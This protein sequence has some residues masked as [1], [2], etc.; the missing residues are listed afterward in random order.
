MFMTLLFMMPVM[1]GPAST[2][3]YNAPQW[4][5]PIPLAWEQHWRTEAKPIEDPSGNYV[6][7]REAHEK[8]SQVICVRRTRVLEVSTFL[9]DQQQG[10][11]RLNLSSERWTVVLPDIGCAAHALITDPRISVESTRIGFWD[12]PGKLPD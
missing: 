6:A 4:E 5:C 10:L 9:E 12:L 2:N 3:I 7:W 8:T 11:F 1:Q